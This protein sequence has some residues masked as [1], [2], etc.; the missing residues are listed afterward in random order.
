M[1]KTYVAI[2]TLIGTIVGAG[3]LG[4]PFVV[5]KSGF[6]IGIVHLIILTLVL[7]ITTLYLGEIALRTKTNHHLSGYAQKY[8]GKKGKMI[9]FTAFSFGVYAALLAYIIGEGTSLSHLFFGS[10]DFTL[11]LGIAFWLILSGIS[12]YGLK[13]LEEGET[14]G[15]ILVII[16]IL[17]LA[18]LYWNNLSIENLTYT[19]LEHVFTPFGVI[20]FAL[21]GFAAVPEIER[22]LGKDKHL[23]KRVIISSYVICFIIYTLFAILVIGT[24][25]QATPEIATIAL[26][27]PFI[28]L[29]ILTMFTSYLALS[30]ALIDTLRFDFR[31]TR[32][33]AWLYTIFIPIILFILL[34]FLDIANFTTILGIGGVISGGLTAILILLMVKNAKRHGT[35]IPPYTIPYSP[36]LTWI[37][38]A[39]FILGAIAEIINIIR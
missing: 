30:M 35:E 36:V 8:L 37:F 22:I 17:S 11:H 7:T 12:Y 6:S 9:M 1:S 18:I 13:A 16:L 3:I 29:G 10:G 4:I 21:L 39:I 33:Q 31:K 27:K 23:T 20:L 32:K 34:E 19:N 26:G 14:I 2:A 28:L 38:S 25:G 15:I 24:K 5:M